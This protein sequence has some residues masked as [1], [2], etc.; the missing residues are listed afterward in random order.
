MPLDKSFS[1]PV[2]KEESGKTPYSG[3]FLREVL[4]GPER[5]NPA[6]PAEEKKSVFSGRGI[7]PKALEKELAKPDSH[8]HLTKEQRKSIASEIEKPGYQ[9]EVR[10]KNVE[11]HLKNLKKEMIQNQKNMMGAKSLAEREA[12]KKEEYIMKEKM[13]L[14]ERMQDPE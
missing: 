6:K 13:R 1:E 9:P 2:R 7:K 10:E 8:T 12:M 5:K 4:F 14:L 3:N 11:K